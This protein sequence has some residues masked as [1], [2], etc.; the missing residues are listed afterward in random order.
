MIRPLFLENPRRRWV[1]TTRQHQ[2][3][4]EYANPIRCMHK[5]TGYPWQWWVVVL[6]CGAA[7]IYFM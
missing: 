5:Q 4:A 2:S 7:G 3:P 6:A 1:E